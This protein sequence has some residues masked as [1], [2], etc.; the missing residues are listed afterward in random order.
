MASP[1]S[2]PFCPTLELGY[3]STALHL[4]VIENQTEIVH[5]LLLKGAD[6][7]RKDAQGYT[8][9]NWAVREGHL[10]VLRPC[11]GCSNGGEH[12]LGRGGV[13]LLCAMKKVM[14]RYERHSFKAEAG[15]RTRAPAAT[16]SPWSFCT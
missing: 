8:A 12:T 10:E 16:A 1:S 13:R 5:S 14:K 15:C 2:N 3:G 7:Q 4:A 6:R 11:V 9:S